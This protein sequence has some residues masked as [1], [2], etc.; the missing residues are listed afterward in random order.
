MPCPPSY[1]ELEFIRLSDQSDGAI[2]KL[3][4]RWPLLSPAIA[5]VE[6]L[7]PR[8]ADIA[9]TVPELDDAR[10]DA[11]ALVERYGSFPTYSGPRARLQGW[12]DREDIALEQA[13]ANFFTE[14][15]KRVDL[16]LCILAT[17]VARCRY[18]RASDPTLLAADIDRLIAS[19]R[20]HREGERAHALAALERCVRVTRDPDAA[21]KLRAEGERI[22]G[23]DEQ[24]LLC[25][26]TALRY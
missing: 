20:M 16:T 9:A 11:R 3:M 12:T 7:R 23:L 17:F 24:T 25:D 5:L 1:E 15:A 19:H 2:A 14:L 13:Y 18:E 8:H 10:V 21:A 4:A 26:R 22:R 6:G